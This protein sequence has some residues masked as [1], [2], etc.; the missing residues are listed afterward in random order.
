MVCTLISKS[1][2]A[3]MLGSLSSTKP[4]YMRIGS[5]SGAELNSLTGLY[6]EIGS[7]KTFVSTDITTLRKVTWQADWTSVEMSGL[8]LREFILSIG[9]AGTE[10]YSYNNLGDAVSFD[11]TNELRVEITFEVF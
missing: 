6:A 11:G 9:S 10:P 7:P 1:G 8:G 3:L 5:G 4:T 2:V